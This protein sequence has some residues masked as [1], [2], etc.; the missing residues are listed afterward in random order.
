MPAALKEAAQHFARG[1]TLAASVRLETALKSGEK[2]DKFGQRVWLAL[3][4]LLQI[5]TRRDAFDKLALAYAKRFESSPPA[6][7]QQSLTE[8]HE[9]ELSCRLTLEPT[10][11][12]GVGTSLR[13]LQG[14][15]AVASRV[16]ID[17]TQVTRIE[18]AGCSILARALQTLRR[19]GKDCRWLAGDS[20]V[21][22][23]QANL[24]PATR[25]HE[26]QW[27][28][29]LE[30]L[31]QLGDQ[32]RFDEV[33]INFA[34]AFEVSPP[35]WE[36]T[37]SRQ[38]SPDAV[39]PASTALL[40]GDVLGRSRADMDALLNTLASGGSHTL[41]ASAMVRIDETSAS[42]L[43]EALAARPSRLAITNLAQLPEIILSVSGVGEFAEL[44]LRRY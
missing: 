16:E 13:T 6:W 30:L 18:D 43:K 19:R 5:L 23:L 1:D 41:D 35:S 38:T 24:N 26:A 25:D 33:A 14:K 37:T 40:Q 8:A 10:L 20:L 29:L 28:L 4:D 22:L 34:V 27:G 11:N 3:F 17:A 39:P 12:A 32:G 9:P 15:L 7:N 31:Q 42:A 2:L 44:Q 21:T 36:A